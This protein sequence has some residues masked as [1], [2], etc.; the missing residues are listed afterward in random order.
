MM[1]LPFNETFY[2]FLCTFLVDLLLGRLLVKDMVECEGL[3]RAHDADLGFIRY[4]R[5]TF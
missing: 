3:V 2:K 5:D 1:C 4:I